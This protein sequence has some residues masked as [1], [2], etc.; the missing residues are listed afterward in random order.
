MNEHLETQNRKATAQTL[1]SGGG[2]QR[3]TI[4]TSPISDVPPIV[5]EVLRSP[6]QPLD[7]ATHAHGATLRA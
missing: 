7:T 1:V 2:L 4:S 5:H 6:D 3:A